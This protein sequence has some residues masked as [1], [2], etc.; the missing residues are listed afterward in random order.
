MAPSEWMRRVRQLEGRVAALSG[1]RTL[2]R[3]RC[4]GEPII[5]KGS[6]QQAVRQ[7]DKRH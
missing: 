5:G 7:S 6:H 3:G 1:E 2:I 4:T